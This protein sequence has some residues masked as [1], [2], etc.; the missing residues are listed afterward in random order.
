M[1]KV[2][3]KGFAISTVIYCILII[4]ILIMGML[5]ST[6]VFSKK[7]TDDLVYSVEK[8]LNDFAQNTYDII[9]ESHREYT[10]TV[11]NLNTYYNESD[12][13]IKSYL[14]NIIGISFVDLNTVEQS[15]IEQYK[16]NS[17][18]I[19]LGYSE[20]VDKVTGYIFNPYSNVRVLIIAANGNIVAPSDCT[21]MFSFY[22]GSNA[23]YGLKYLDTSTV[24]IMDGMFAD[25]SNIT[26]LDISDLNTTNV[27]SMANL[28]KNCASLTT[29]TGL[30]TRNLN[31][32]TT[33]E[34]LFSNCSNINEIDLSNLNAAELTNIQHMFQKCSKL[35]TINL[36]DITINSITNMYGLFNECTA[37]TSIDVSAFNTANVT[38]MHDLFAG[39]TNLTEIQ[40]ID[41]WNVESVT[42]MVSMFY[43]CKKLESLNLSNFQTSSLQKCRYM[44]YNC[45]SLNSLNLDNFNTSKVTD[46]RHMFHNCSN[47]TVLYL[48]SFDFSSIPTD[49]DSMYTQMFDGMSKLTNIT[50]KN[51]AAQTFVKKLVPSTVTVTIS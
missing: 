47:I 12:S 22:K 5:F 17:I 33:F 10:R 38:E 13:S 40:G 3:N 8:D 14:D 19:D 37:L 43:G 28:F 49:N 48:S 23:I 9:S 4:A 45:T 42:D 46:T 32:C 31:N 15:T 44:F 29:V 35:T 11:K 20:N 6:I 51:Q 25:C 26:T 50:V 27:T 41:T 7:T 34:G 18:I 36:T 39:C 24:K 21:N 16:S 2:N 1:K 30:N